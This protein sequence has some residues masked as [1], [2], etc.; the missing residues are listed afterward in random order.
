[1]RLLTLAN[2]F[3]RGRIHINVPVRE[4]FYPEE[5][6]NIA[7]SK[8]V[9]IIDQHL[10][11]NLMMEDTK[12]R[13][14][15][16]LN[17]YH[18][19]LIVAGQEKYD[20]EFVRT[21]QSFVNDYHIPVVA[22]VISNCQLLNNGIKYQDA[23]L[24]IGH[25]ELLSKLTPDLLISF[26]KSVISKQLKL[27]L[28]KYRPTEHWHIQLAGEVADTFQS[29]TNVFHITRSAFFKAL[30]SPTQ[31]G[32]KEQ[33]TFLDEWKE[34]DQRVDQC[35]TRQFSDNIFSEFSAVKIVLDTLPANSILHL[36]N[37]MPVRYANYLGIQDETVEVF[38]NRGTSGIDGSVSTAVGCALSTDKLVTLIT[39]DMA[40]FYDRNAFW[41]NY[42]PANLRVIILNNH[43]GGIFG[44]IK[45]PD[46]QPELE[47]L[48]ETHQPLK[49]E[50]LCKEFDIDYTLCPDFAS[51]KEKIRR[52]YSIGN[53]A[54]ILEI[55][56]EKEINKKFFTK[57]KYTLNSIYG[58]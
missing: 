58:N 54:K 18:R 31:S 4:P 25:E 53:R 15:Q 16:K 46:R 30:Q 44:L 12:E 23:F 26:G 11:S 21:L 24:G 38:A 41:N 7:Y 9:R 27:F 47:E 50:N 57:F 56:T 37:S 8:D 2:V 52:F 17:A 55:E 32:M 14:H 33:K 6:E 40:F 49:A 28:R 3:H 5:H 13:L 22:D 43:G 48:F 51:L 34:I 42:L 20:A 1:M 35:Y 10:P 45:G 29:L 39:G 36:A 19:I